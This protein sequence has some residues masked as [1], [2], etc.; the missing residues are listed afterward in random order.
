MSLPIVKKQ[1]SKSNCIETWSISSVR[2]FFLVDVVKKGHIYKGYLG[3]WSYA[4][5]YWCGG[6]LLLMHR[7]SLLLLC[8]R[9]WNSI[10]T[11]LTLSFSIFGGVGFNSPSTQLSSFLTLKEDRY[12]GAALAWTQTFDFCQ[13]ST[14]I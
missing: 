2:Y 7:I 13:N 12:T 9:P 10:W 14:L 11:Y 5:M 3:T 8:F 1:G 4:H 6:T